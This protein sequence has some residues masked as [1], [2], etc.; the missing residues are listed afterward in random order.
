MLLTPD[1]Y[2]NGFLV[3]DETIAGV[4]ELAGGVFSAYV[5]NSLTGET[6][7]YREFEAV[8]PALLYLRDLNRNWKFEAVG[9]GKTAA[10][11]AAGSCQS[12]QC[13]GC[14]S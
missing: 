8:E 3:D 5:S 11:G 9:C 13:A 6:L 10:T 2:M 7:A 14:G 12:G 1:N 4:T